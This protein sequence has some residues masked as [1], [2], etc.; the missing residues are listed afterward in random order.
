MA[1][2]IDTIEV[3]VEL[4]KAGDLNAIQKLLPKQSLFGRWADHAS[5]GHGIIMSSYPE[6]ELGAVWFVRE[7]EDNS[8]GTEGQWV[9]FD[10]LLIDLVELTTVANFK[11][12]PI[13]TIVAEP[14]GDAYQ[15]VFN[16]HWESRNNVLIN[17]YMA[18]SGP[19]KILRW[20]KGE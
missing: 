18:D 19:W 7:K 9:I 1:D 10:D 12:A 14:R 20:G 3:P 4:I 11:N 8:D 17:E 15:K 6:D 5:L 13:G 16:D 2:T